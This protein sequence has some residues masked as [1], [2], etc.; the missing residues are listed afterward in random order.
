[1]D[2]NGKAQ[3]RLCRCK[4]NNCENLRDSVMSSLS[5]NHVW[6]QKTIRIEFRDR[7]MDTMSINKF[8]L[9]NSISR[10]I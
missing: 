2:Q 4:W 6:T 9:Y 3:Q 1:M 10:H 8:A 5:Q 7:N